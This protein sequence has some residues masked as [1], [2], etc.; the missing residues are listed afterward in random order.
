MTTILTGLTAF[1]L[2]AGVLVQVALTVAL[3][4]VFY[5]DLVFLVE[6]ALDCIRN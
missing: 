1:I 6:E 3:V 5:D 4:V 2:I